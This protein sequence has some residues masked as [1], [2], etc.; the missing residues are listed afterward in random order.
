MFSII[1][2]V[3]ECEFLYSL[4]ASYPVTF[5]SWVDG[6]WPKRRSGIWKSGSQSQRI[7]EGTQDPVA[8]SEALTQVFSVEPMIHFMLTP[9]PT[10]V[11]MILLTSFRFLPPLSPVVSS[12]PGL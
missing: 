12:Q 4:T 5:P 6:G 2:Q 8:P 10:P 11:L 1:S 9:D 3:H 7:R